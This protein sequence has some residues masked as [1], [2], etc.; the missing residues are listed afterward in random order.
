MPFQQGIRSSANPDALIGREFNEE[1]DPAGRCRCPRTPCRGW[2]RPPG[3]FE[4][5]RSWSAGAGHPGGRL[6][7]IRS[8]I[9]ESWQRSI[10][11]KAN[12]DIPE[13]PLAMDGEELEEYRSQHPLAAIM[14]VVLRF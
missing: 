5:R 4:A 14:P 10:Q 11:L 8:L 6:P 3:S 12:P 1:C 13:A 2:P 7:G 9:Q